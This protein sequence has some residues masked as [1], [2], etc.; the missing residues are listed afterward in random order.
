MDDNA[1]HLSEE[2]ETE[3]RKR[4]LQKNI[5]SVDANRQSYDAS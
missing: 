4:N 2:S 1:S 3:K 5:R